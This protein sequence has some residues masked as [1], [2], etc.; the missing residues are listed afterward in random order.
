MDVLI[1]DGAGEGNVLR[2]KFDET[3][4]RQPRSLVSF[5]DQ[6]EATGLAEEIGPVAKI[7][8]T[9]IFNAVSGIS[10]ISLRPKQI[11]YI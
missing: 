3:V 4:S 10:L 8:V 1:R 9:H 6:A 5:R 2:L 7:L 11:I